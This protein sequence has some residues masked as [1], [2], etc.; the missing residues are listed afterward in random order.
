M[1]PSGLG[2]SVQPCVEAY[3]D[4]SLV[5]HGL[6]GSLLPVFCT[7]PQAGFIQ[8]LSLRLSQ[9]HFR[10]TEEGESENQKVRGLMVSHCFEEGETKQTSKHPH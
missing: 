4:R 10:N 6:S 2:D 7:L 1:A 3:S 8:A 9:N 5:Q